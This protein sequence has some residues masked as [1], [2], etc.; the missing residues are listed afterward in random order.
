VEPLTHPDPARRRRRRWIWAFSGLIVATVIVIALLAAAVPLS[1]DALRH[2]V[3]A[4]LSERFDGDVTLGDLHLRIF[5]S[6]HAEGSSLLIRKRG[7]PD[8]PPLI[9][10]NRFAADGD[11]LGLMRKH[12]AHVRLE[13]LDIEIPPKPRHAD[14]DQAHLSNGSQG[15]PATTGATQPTGGEGLS[16]ARD[17]EAGVVVDAMDSVD[18]RLAI[19]SSDSG[20]PPKVWAIHT[21]HMQTVGIGQAMPYSATLTNG[22]PRG[23]IATKGSFGP[24]QRDEPGNTPLGGTYTFDHADLSIFNGISGILSSRGRFDGT[25]ARIDAAGE[26]DTPDFAIKVGGHPFAL[27][28]KY[29]SIIDGTN[30]NTVLERIDASFLQSALVAKGGVVDTPGKGGRTVTLDI[31]MDRAR[32]EDIMTMTVRTP[33]PP[34]KGALKLAT[35]FRLPPGERDVVERL[36]LDGRF[37]IARARFTNY[38]VQAK[39]DELSHRGRGRKQDTVKEAVASNFEGR[40]RLAGGQLHLPTLQFAVPGATVKLAGTYALRPET[41]D[42]RGA[43]LLDA[44]VSETQTGI[45]S[46]LLKAVDPLFRRNGGGSSLPIKISGPRSDPSFGLDTHRL[47]RRGDTP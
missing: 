15:A 5:P 14:D 41:L 10:V 30:G 40:F 29:H 37:A 36:Q 20:K 23:E 8:V 3:V 42:F 22:I 26:T 38:D 33:T 45:K 2:R 4:T 25:L 12:V 35:K 11:L 27:H 17:L 6:V 34:M 16:G 7:R 18:A 43:L 32:V 39:I 13:G 31:V 21:L 44:K 47:F 46:L 19:I 9:S 1:S 24:W 28:T